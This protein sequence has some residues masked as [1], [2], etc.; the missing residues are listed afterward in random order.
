MKYDFFNA[1][2][3]FTPEVHIK[4]YVGRGRGAVDREF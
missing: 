1:G 3:I 2:L 4:K